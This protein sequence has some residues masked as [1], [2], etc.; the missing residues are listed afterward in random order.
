MPPAVEARDVTKQYGEI[1]ALDGVSLTVEPGECVALLGPNG[2][3]KSTLL[4]CLTT[5]KRPTEGRVRVGGADVAEAPGAVRRA[6]GVAFQEPLA[7]KH[8]TAREVLVHHARLYGIDPATSE[9]RADDL[10]AFVGLADRAEDRVETFSGGMKRR[11][12]LARVLMTDPEVLVLDEPTTGLDPR[13]R[14]DVQDRI[15][16]LAREG[17]TVLFAT[18]DLHEAQ[19]LAER[20]A[21]LDEGR[22][23]AEDRPRELARRLGHRVVRVELPDDGHP[24]LVQ[25]ALADLDGVDL[26]ETGD[27]VELVLT[28]AAPSPGQVVDA[29]EQA[30]LAYVSVTVR[31]PDLGDVFLE[32]TGRSLA[33]EPA[34]EEAA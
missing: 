31:E 34:T 15:R 25:D 5:L 24:D 8:L 23:I 22:L 6:I 19:R 18:H 12:D 16:T 30:D 7:S 3:G 10:V 13:G 21:I 11:L 33:R 27:G 1:T 29:L 17:T 2:A 28:E 14:A 4:E 9:D 20:V 26:L 32:L